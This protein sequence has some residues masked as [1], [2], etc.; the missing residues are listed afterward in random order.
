MDIPTHRHR[1]HYIYRCISMVVKLFE[2]WSWA[3]GLD[4]ISAE[5]DE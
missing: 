2:A 4:D 1:H 5:V 3:L